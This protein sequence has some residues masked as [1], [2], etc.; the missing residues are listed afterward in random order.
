M[1]VKCGCPFLKA[2]YRG[3]PTEHHEPRARVRKVAPNSMLGYDIMLEYRVEEIWG[4]IFAF[5]LFHTLSR[6]GF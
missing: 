1:A 4:M 6:L 2:F 5:G 3:G